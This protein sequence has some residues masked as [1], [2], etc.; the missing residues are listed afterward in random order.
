MTFD[1]NSCC[2]VHFVDALGESEA[3]F[4]LDDADGE[5]ERDGRGIERKREWSTNR[6]RRMA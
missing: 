2:H 5:R 4:G 1:S 6:K 3:P